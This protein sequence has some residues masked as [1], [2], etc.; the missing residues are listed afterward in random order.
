MKEKILMFLDLVSK[1]SDE[2]KWLAYIEF[3]LVFS[4]L[5]V[6]HYL[7]WQF[8]YQS[9]KVQHIQYSFIFTIW[10]YILFSTFLRHYFMY[11]DA[12]TKIDS[13]KMMIMILILILWFSKEFIDLFSENSNPEFM[14]IMFNYV[15][16]AFWFI[17][18]D[19]V[20]NFIKKNKNYILKTV[21]WIKEKENKKED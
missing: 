16:V 12:K 17:L 6:W 9:D 10:A 2:I 3:I 21:D 14:D 20:I 8:F 11:L 1:K 4:M 7:N 19:L 18:I 15:W 5:W 13:K